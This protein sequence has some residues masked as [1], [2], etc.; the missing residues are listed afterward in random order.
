MYVINVNGDQIE[1]SM[2]NQVVTF[3]RPSWCF[4]HFFFY[5]RKEALC[6]LFNRYGSSPDLLALNCLWSKCTYLRRLFCCWRPPLRQAKY[7][8]AFAQ[9]FTIEW[10]LLRWS[11]S[12]LLPECSVPIERSGVANTFASQTHTLYP[13][14]T[15][16]TSKVLTALNAI[17]EHFKNVLAK[18][19]CPSYVQCVQ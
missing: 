8:F 18:T 2:A 16:S 17:K 19:S 1:V 3:E 13:W 9:T 4:S 7:L 15:H 5:I 10:K 12:L 6:S 14:S 11:F